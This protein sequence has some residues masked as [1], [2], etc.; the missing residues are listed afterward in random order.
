LKSSFLDLARSVFVRKDE[1]FRKRLSVF[2]ICLVIS[3]VIWSTLKFSE[4]YDT[5]IKV[6]VTFSNLPR[7]KVLTYT[8]DSVILVEV[9][10]KGSNLFRM[11]YIEHV[12][13]VTISLKYLPVFRNS[14][15]YEGIITPSVLI[16]DIEREQNLI[17]KI[18]S[19]SPDTIH[20]VFESKKTRKLPVRAKLELSFE[21]EYINYGKINFSPDSVTVEGPERIVAGL[22]YADIG[23][24]KT[25]RLNRNVSGEKTFPNDSLNRLLTFI[26]P[27]VSYTIPV[28]KF[29][30]AAAE[31]PVKIINNNDLKARLLPDKVKVYY[32]IA[33]S[34]YSKVEPEMIQALA[35]FSTV[36]IQEDDRIKITVGN[37]PSFIH[38]N[39]IVPE[40]V[41]FIIIK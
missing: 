33:L 25:A 15:A 2:L 13:P 24:I 18:I 41:E 23:T 17:G 5:V 1:K 28:D 27:S 3:T 8:S 37:S 16:N 36:N 26:P 29:T 11:L 21:K 20:L 9:M 32:T 4:E 12:A 22:E 40:R 35:D 10:E 31:V 30:E 14:G 19:I 38:I 39:K 34:D 7:N 6:P